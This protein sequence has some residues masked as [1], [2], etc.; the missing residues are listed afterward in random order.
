MCNFMH[1]FEFLLYLNKKY[2]FEFRKFKAV[3]LIMV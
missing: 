1:Y 2:G 3:Y